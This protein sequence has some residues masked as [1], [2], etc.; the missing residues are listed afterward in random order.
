MLLLLCSC[1]EKVKPVAKVVPHV[2]VAEVIPAVATLVEII[3]MVEHRA[4][5]S[6]EWG[7]THLEMKLMNRDELKT[8][9]GARA[10]V[11]FLSGNTYLKVDEKSFI[12]IW[13]KAVDERKV[14]VVGLPQ[15]TV[16]GISTQ[17]EDLEIRTP[18]GWIKAKDSEII[19]TSKDMKNGFKV[20][21]IK[22]SASIVT[23]KNKSILSF[24]RSLKII[25]PVKV[26]S[27]FMDSIPLGSTLIKE[28]KFLIEKPVKKEFRTRE[29]TISFSGI[30]EGDFT[31]WANGVLLSPNAGRFAH[32]FKLVPGLN[33]VTLQISDPGKKNVEYFI[34][35][36]TRDTGP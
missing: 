20:T 5:S 33:V 13:D 14:H 9:E 15:G 35:K 27:T 21:V 8:G 19:V 1:H 30:W 10:R 6:A 12:V 34:Y 32:L 22:G 31:V 29:E 2:P 28:D 36:I 4:S 24:G 11:K 25:Q 17:Q 26:Q 16:K 18:A 3:P 7:E 23:D